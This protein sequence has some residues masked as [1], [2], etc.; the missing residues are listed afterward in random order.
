MSNRCDI[1]RVRPTSN[2]KLVELS[3]IVVPRYQCD[4][5]FGIGVIL[6]LSAVAYRDTRSLAATPAT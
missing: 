1:P 5:H 4:G 6:A 3:C 2:G